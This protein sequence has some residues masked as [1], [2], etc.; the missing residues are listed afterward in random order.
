SLV[1]APFSLAWPTVM[2]AI[3]KR[4]DAASIFRIVIRWFTLV[5]MFA[6]YALALAGIGVLYSFFPLAYA[7]AASIIPVIAISIMFYGVYIMFTIGISVQRKTWFAVI[8]T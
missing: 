5:L 4:N 2:F 7:S 1:I 3:A 6:A 8:F